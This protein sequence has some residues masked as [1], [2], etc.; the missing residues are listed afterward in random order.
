MNFT[1]INAT[2]GTSTKFTN[3][4]ITHFLH[5]HLEEFGDTEEDI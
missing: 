3:K 1:Y 2:T 5:T 4:I